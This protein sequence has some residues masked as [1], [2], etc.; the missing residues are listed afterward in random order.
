MSKKRFTKSN[1]SVEPHEQSVL[2]YIFD[3]VLVLTSLT[4]FAFGNEQQKQQKYFLFWGS[5]GTSHATPYVSFRLWENVQ[6]VR[7]LH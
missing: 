4:G 2:T 3:W 7:R 6:N 1:H 5:L